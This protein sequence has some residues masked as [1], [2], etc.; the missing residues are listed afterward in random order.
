V[1]RIVFFKKPKVF[2]DWL[3]QSVETIFLLKIS[4]NRKLWVWSLWVLSLGLAGVTL[5]WD[6]TLISNMLTYMLTYPHTQYHSV[7][8]HAY[9]HTG[10]MTMWDLRTMRQ[11]F[12]TAWQ[13]SSIVLT[14]FR[15]LS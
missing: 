3:R 7:Y 14:S 5:L 15:K 4:R 10:L 13:S 11:L 12:P 6:L 9:I 8:S 2:A 1:T